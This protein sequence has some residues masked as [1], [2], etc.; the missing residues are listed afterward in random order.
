[1]IR[2]KH[3]Q[4][5]RREKDIRRAEEAVARAEEVCVSARVYFR[6]RGS[7][8]H[9]QHQQQQRWKVVLLVG[10]FAFS[11]E[12]L[13]GSTRVVGPLQDSTIEAAEG[14]ERPRPTL[15]WGVSPTTTNCATPMVVAVLTTRSKLFFRHCSKSR[16]C[17]GR[18]TGASLAR[19][20]S[21]APA[22]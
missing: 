21:L 10:V 9:H 20:L 19:S 13:A 1:V 7:Q 6:R 18:R 2:K 16:S 11:R 17:V 15:D 8:Q 5:R 22:H 3:Q 14:E 4:Q 12:L